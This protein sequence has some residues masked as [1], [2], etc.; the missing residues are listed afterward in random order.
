MHMLALTPGG[1]V[2]CGIGSLCRR[3]L[4]ALFQLFRLGSKC[5]PAKPSCQF[6]RQIFISFFK[7]FT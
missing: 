1:Q 4:G 7:M 2:T 5:L 6:N 3:G